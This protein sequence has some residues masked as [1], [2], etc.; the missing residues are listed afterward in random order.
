MLKIILIA[1]AAALVGF[2]AGCFWA[3]RRNEPEPPET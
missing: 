1:W 3:G 2:L